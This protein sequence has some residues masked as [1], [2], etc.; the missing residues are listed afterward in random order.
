MTIA[1]SQKRSNCGRKSSDGQTDRQ[2]LVE[3]CM[4]IRPT[5]LRSLRSLRF[6]KNKVEVQ[7]YSERF[8]LESGKSALHTK[9]KRADNNITL[10]HILPMATFLTIV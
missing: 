8:S 1:L 10:C 6:D 4:G 9:A 7:S 5:T 2:L 3:I